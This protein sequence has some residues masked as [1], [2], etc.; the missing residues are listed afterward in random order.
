MGKYQFNLL[1]FGQK[2]PGFSSV[3]TETMQ[4]RERNVR[5]ITQ[6]KGTTHVMLFSTRYQRWWCIWIIHKNNMREGE[7]PE[8]RQREVSLTWNWN[9]CASAC[10][11]SRGRPWVF[12]QVSRVWHDML[13]DAT[14]TSFCLSLTSL[15][16]LFSPAQELWGLWGLTSILN[17]A[18]QSHVECRIKPRTS[19]LSRLS[20]LNFYGVF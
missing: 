7:S 8:R 9:R 12:A 3:R 13:L 5:G 1:C 10:K 4:I 18:W 19:P 16:F 20:Y 11:Q 2:H 14:P 17:N 15:H 6:L